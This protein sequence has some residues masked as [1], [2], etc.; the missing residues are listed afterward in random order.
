MESPFTKEDTRQ[1][2][3]R[4]T[5]VRYR[6][7]KTLLEKHKGRCARCG[8]SEGVRLARVRKGIKEAKETDYT[9]LCHQCILLR[10]K[11][12]KEAK[13]RAWKEKQ[14]T[15]QVTRTAFFYR[16]RKKVFERDGYE[17]VWCGTTENLG[18]GPLIPESRGGRLEI[19]NYVCTCQHCRPAKGDKLPLEFLVEPI[20]IDEYL[21][22]ELDHSL[23]VLDDPGKYVKIR[24]FL[25]SEISEFLHG[26]TVRKDLDDPTRSRAEQLN[27]KLL[28]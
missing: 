1:R 13:A 11:E 26:L 20:M 7:R 23:R 21:K 28:S 14:A 2:E 16:I 27:V 9:L 22:G 25:F 10:V 19:N 6:A 17:C 18:L 24:F 15:R 4:Q 5:Q 8:R 12:A 3:N